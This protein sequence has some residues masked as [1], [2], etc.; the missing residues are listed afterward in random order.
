MYISHMNSSCHDLYP[1]L[2]AICHI[3]HK[4]LWSWIFFI[5][6]LWIAFHMSF[7]DMDLITVG[8]WSGTMVNIMS[9]VPS[10]HLLSHNLWL[11]SPAFSPGGEWVSS[12]IPSL[13][14]HL[15]ER[16]N[17]VVMVCCHLLNF[18]NMWHDYTTKYKTTMIQEHQHNMSF[19]ESQKGV[20]VILL[21]KVFNIL[22]G[23]KHFLMNLHMILKLRNRTFQPI[24]FSFLFLEL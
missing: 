13:S 1:L 6:S 11:K 12:L 5:A 23:N 22:I 18:L 16:I 3:A 7:A 4:I 21:C 17:K 19:H 9:L 2:C 14:D 20:A 8:R 10:S 24:F 15:W